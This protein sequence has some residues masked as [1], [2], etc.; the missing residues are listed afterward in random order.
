MDFYLLCL[1][2]VLG[3]ITWTVLVN[4]V[5]FKKT[6]VYYLFFLAYFLAVLPVILAIINFYFLKTI[7]LTNPVTFLMPLPIDGYLNLFILSDTVLT[8]ML[9]TGIVLILI[10]LIPVLTDRFKDRGGKKTEESKV[11]PDKKDK[12]L[13][14]YGTYLSLMLDFKEKDPKKE[15]EEVKKDN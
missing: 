5:T 10:K 4:H 2:Y 6:R 13:I 8:F 1:L 14:E 11:D 3:F 12:E 9:I 7:D 15:D